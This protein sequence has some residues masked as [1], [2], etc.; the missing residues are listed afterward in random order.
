MLR[1]VVPVGLQNRPCLIRNLQ[2]LAFARWSGQIADQ[3]VHDRLEG[4]LPLPGV[5]FECLCRLRNAV[6]TQHGEGIAGATDVDDAAYQAQHSPFLTEQVR[7]PAR[8]DISKAFQGS[9]S[10]DVEL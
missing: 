1:D 6:S 7:R 4:F 10:G 2:H 5:F 9:F 3:E 8:G